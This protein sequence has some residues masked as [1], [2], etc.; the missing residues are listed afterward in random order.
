MSVVT[1]VEHSL[2]AQAHKRNAKV[3]VKGLHHLALS[4]STRGEGTVGLCPGNCKPHQRP[5]GPAGPP[6]RHS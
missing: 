5:A 4:N 3:Q 1:S 2:Q 6:S